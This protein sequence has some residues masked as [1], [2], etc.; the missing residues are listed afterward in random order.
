MCRLLP[1]TPRVSVSVIGEIWRLDKQKKIEED[2]PTARC[3]E[4]EWD[5][6]HA[7]F[8]QLSPDV[9]LRS[10]SDIVSLASCRVCV[11]RCAASRLPNCWSA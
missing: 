7:D 4:A 1:P 8:Y 2:D 6:V 5:G 10:C 11:D 9:A 3:D